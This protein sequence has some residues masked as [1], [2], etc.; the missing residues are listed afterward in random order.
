MNKMTR[1]LHVRM[2]MPMILQLLLL[3]SSATSFIQSFNSPAITIKTSSSSRTSAAALQSTVEADETT[4]TSPAATSIKKTKK[5]WFPIRPAD[6]LS[7][8]N[9][10][11]SLV[12]SAYLRHI[13]VETEEMADL[14]MNL[15]LNGGKKRDDDDDNKG[16]DDEEDGDNAG[17]EVEGTEERD[18]DED[19]E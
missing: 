10:Y 6:A 15:Y 1:R 17:D 11:N 5:T 4:S 18:D 13:L 14:V 3:L 19:G 12:K 16:K 8:N 2:I 7:P 9:D